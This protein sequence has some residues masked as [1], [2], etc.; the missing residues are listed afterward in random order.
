M[1]EVFLT[2]VI[3]TA[4]GLFLAMLGVCYKSRCTRINFCGVSIERDAVLE[5][6]LDELALRQQPAGNQTKIDTI[7]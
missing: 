2:F 6:R 5:E 3:T 4:S 1:S 7:I